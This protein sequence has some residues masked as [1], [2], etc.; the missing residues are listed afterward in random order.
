LVLVHKGG[1]PA[2]VSRSTSRVVFVALRKLFTEALATGRSEPLG[3]DRQ[4]IAALP[5]G[6]TSVNRARHPFDDAVARA[7][8]D[9]ANLKHFA[10]TFDPK[11]RGL[12]DVWETLAYTGRRCSEVLKLRYECLGRYH[13][14]P[15]LWHD[16]TKVGNFDAGIRIPEHLYARL[17]E[18]R[19]TTLFRFHRRHGR[20]PTAQERAEMALFPSTVRN[21]TETKS[22]SYG[23]FHTAFKTWVD[24]MD[25]GRCVPHQARH[26]LA[27]RLLAAGA[28]LTHIRR[29]LGQV[30]DRMAEHYAQVAG[31]EL[32]DVLARVWVA[33]P[34][35][36]NPGQ[37]ITSA[38]QPM[39][40]Q[41]AQAMAV[42]VGRHCTPTLGG[43]CTAQVV[44]DGGQCP[45][46]LDCES[47][48]Q[49]VLTGADLLY[50]RRKREHW[51]SIAERAPDDATAKWLHQAFEPTARAIDGLEEALGG[52]GLLDQ[53]L[54]LDLR[55]PQDYFSRM[56]NVGF[57][58]F[59]LAGEASEDLALAQAA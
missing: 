1:A 33:G 15:M 34:G 23:H 44:V 18:R 27:T 20:G 39:S 58:V 9:E 29:Y 50:W 24:E 43:L 55:R 38:A 48:D 11:D 57:P 21:Q 26:T 32:D 5:R 12:R 52:L 51:Y 22:I 46:N 6:G 54:A 13:G 59:D 37:Q 40:A 19:R 25:L 10:D 4:F 3:L 42:D 41:L 30:S 7:L 14:V 47:C 36:I 45:R 35:A 53:A 16:Q 49:L 56:W 28:T 2:V 31:S 17:D 8:T